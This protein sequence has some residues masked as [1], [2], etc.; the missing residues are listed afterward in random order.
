MAAATGPKRL[1]VAL[2]LPEAHRLEL[3]RLGTHLPGVRWHAP[4]KLHLTLAFLGDAVAPEVQRLLRETL[5]RVNVPPFYLPLAGAGSFGGTR[6]R[7]LWVGVGGGH[8]HLLALHRA[9]NEAV[10]AAGGQPEMKPFVPHVTVAYCGRDTS[11]EAAGRWVREHAGFDAGLMHV[12]GFTLY[13]SVGGVYSKVSSV[14]WP[15]D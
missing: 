13:D 3:V 11:P 12:T 6:P 8:P 4:E 2:D 14:S 1:F 5:P 10:L 9:V 15:S 7:A